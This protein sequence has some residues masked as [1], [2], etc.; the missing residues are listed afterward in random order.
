MKEAIKNIV[1]DLGGVLIKLNVPRCIEAFEALMGK[2]NLRNVLGMDEEGEG[3]KSV[4]VASRQLMADFERGLIKSA[5]FIEQIRSYC[6]PDTTD[7][8]VQN[9]WMAMLGDLPQ[10]R[11][12]QVAQW[13]KQGYHLY[14][15]SNGNELHFE[16]INRKYHLDKYFER[17]FLSQ[18]MHL[19]KPE[20]EIFRQV[21]ETIGGIGENTVFIDDLEANRLAAAATV[22]W[23]C[24]D[25]LQSV[26]F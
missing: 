13:R 10:E 26:H 21:N 25:A 9:A 20:P 22:G 1:C 23:Q 19:A 11:L 4:S 6:H 18:E 3:V 14:L 17:M 16:Y 7:E 12:E 8:M 2:D 15:L 5:D 24:F